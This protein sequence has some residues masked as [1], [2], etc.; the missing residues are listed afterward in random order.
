MTINTTIN[1]RRN[2]NAF[3]ITDNTARVSPRL[4]DGSTITTSDCA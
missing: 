3:C 1:R 2:T 4:S